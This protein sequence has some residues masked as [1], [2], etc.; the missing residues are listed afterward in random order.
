MLK[1]DFSNYKRRRT[2]GQSW[3]HGAGDGGIIINESHLKKRKRKGGKGR[4]NFV[5]VNRCGSI[6]NVGDPPQTDR[7]ETI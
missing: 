7:R 5:G 3:Q 1:E 6:G 2:R 4:G